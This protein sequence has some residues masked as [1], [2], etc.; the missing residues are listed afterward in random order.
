MTCSVYD[1]RNKARN[2]THLK[3]EITSILT[4][5]LPAASH[6]V[7]KSEPKLSEFFVSRHPLTTEF[8]SDILIQSLQP[9]PE[10]ASNLLVDVTIA[11]PASKEYVNNYK[12]SGFAG[13]I[14]AIKKRLDA[15]SHFQI[16]DESIAEFTVFGIDSYG[17]F[18]NEAFSLVKRFSRLCTDNNNSYSERFQF[19]LQRLSIA[20]QTARAAQVEIMRSNVILP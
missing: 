5:Y 14:R 16:S 2:P 12:Y 17:G 7:V 20:L 6:K 9:N 1:L 13:D 15:S 3:R 19:F 4:S 11:H 18:G 8:R 10:Q